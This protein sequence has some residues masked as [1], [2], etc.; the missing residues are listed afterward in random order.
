VPGAVARGAGTAYFRIVV[1]REH[2]VTVK[3]HPCARRITV[4]F[5]KEYWDE[6]VHPDTLAPCMRRISGPWHGV[7]R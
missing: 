6:C 1:N 3:W 2:P 5:F 4:T 7:A